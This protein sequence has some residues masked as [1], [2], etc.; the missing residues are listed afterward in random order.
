MSAMPKV[1]V[2]DEEHDRTTLLAFEAQSSQCADARRA[3][4]VVIASKLACLECYEIERTTHNRLLVEELRVDNDRMH[5]L[6]QIHQATR[7]ETK[8]QTPANRDYGRRV[9]PVHAL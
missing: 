5:L 9:S 7:K 1:F 8:Y 6:M 3:L 4:N 2:P